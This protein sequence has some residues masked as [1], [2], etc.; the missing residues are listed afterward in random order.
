MQLRTLI[1][2]PEVS[3]DIDAA[4][5]TF[6][7]VHESIEAIE[8]Y[9]SRRPEAGTHRSGIYWIYRQSGCKALKIPDITVLYSFTDN[10]VTLH[11]ALF[12][13]SQ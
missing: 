4:S 2:D 10:E 5:K 7:L 1:H 9:L 12:R 6:R 8:W 13:G 11:A 3:Q